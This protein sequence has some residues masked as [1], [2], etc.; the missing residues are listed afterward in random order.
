M[1]ISCDAGH[2][3]VPDSGAVGIRKEDDL[4]KAVVKSLATFASDMGNQIK[5]CTP[6]GRPFANVG[7]SLAYRC[8][9]A[10]LSGSELHLCIHFN[11]GGGEGVEAYAI[12][13]SGHEYATKICAAIS[14]LGYGNRGT[15]DGSHLYVVRNTTMA[16]V[17]V[18]CSFVDNKYDM[19]K[20][21]SDD[22]AKAILLG[23]TGRR[24]INTTPIPIIDPQI[25][26]IQQDLN[27]LFKYNL[28]VDGI[29]GPLT[30]VAMDKA[31]LIFG[32]TG[33][34]ALLKATAEVLTFPLDGVT[35][36]HCEYATRY[37]QFRVGNGGD[38]VGVF[39]FGMEAKVK[40]FQGSK[41]LVQ[42]GIVGPIT[43]A[44]FI[45]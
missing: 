18:E 16:C 25:K 39:Y 43:W 19:D 27:I 26:K 3:C 34:I 8:N 42:D 29:L 15:K 5:D 41:G 7:Q 22:L 33:A 11:A 30:K 35:A 10:N 20:Y 28:A 31:N 12:S 21:N 17:L 45:K 36:P 38:K 14:S 37:I 44:A 2:N 6:Y 4:T 9:L 13:S 32:V 40:I 23:V 1:N 24:V